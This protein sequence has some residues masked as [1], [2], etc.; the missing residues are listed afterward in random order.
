[1]MD[2]ADCLPR[3]KILHPTSP[4]TQSA[5][6]R[7]R[8]LQQSKTLARRGYADGDSGVVNAARPLNRGF[9]NLRS[10]TI[11]VALCCGLNAGAALPKKISL[12]H[13]GHARTCLVHVPAPLRSST[14]R[15]PAL[16]LVFHGGGG[17]A[18]QIMGTSGFNTISTREGFI[19]AY[20]DA[21]DKHWNDGRA[22]EKFRD[23]D[24]KI[25][26]VA[27]IAA[28]IDRLSQDHAIDRRRIYATGISN[29]GIFSQRLAIELGDRLAGVSSLTAQIATELRRAKPKGKVSVQFINGTKDPFVPYPG[30]PVTPNFFPRLARFQKKENRGTVISTD[31]AVRYWL[32]HNSIT[33][34][35][36]I[37]K[38]SD[39]N[40]K[41]NC[42]AET[43]R[44]S[45]SGVSVELLKVMGGGHTWPGGKSRQYLPVRVIGETCRDF[46]AS[47]RIW[48]F[49]KAHP[50]VK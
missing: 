44:W 10:A 30:G 22:S 4:P 42:T 31:D 32:S 20:P 12:Q 33:G 14:A 28:L 18:R 35:P 34:K 39:R 1:M 11:L 36:T 43:Q 50:K 26:D 49:F 17:N 41:D 23:H 3:P 13:Q 47:E 27:F 7:C 19:A 2:R 45:G 46:E 24:S 8:G 9:V 15:K 25:N 48:E 6:E 40:R 37:E 5:K 16:V 21:I 38:L 29:G